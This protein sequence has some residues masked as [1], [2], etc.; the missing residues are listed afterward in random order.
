MALHPSGKIEPNYHS[1]CVAS[2]FALAAMMVGEYD[3]AQSILNECNEVQRKLYGEGAKNQDI[4][5]THRLWGKLLRLQGRKGID[6]GF[7][8]A[9][10]NLLLAL[11]MDE[12]IMGEDGLD[13]AIELNELALLLDE[14]SE[15]S[16]A[17]EY[18]ER[19]LKI[20][21]KLLDTDHPLV[22]ESLYALAAILYKQG[23]LVEAFEKAK[24]ALRICVK[25]DLVEE[26]YVVKELWKLLGKLCYE[27]A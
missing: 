17:R 9:R 2:N 26:H 22:A 4:A 18:A 13:C 23:E 19:A 12:E 6:S 5:I 14:T 25:K 27:L 15:L 20:R 10:D 7:N 21:E 1:L 3:T 24:R 11:A 16:Q 8:G